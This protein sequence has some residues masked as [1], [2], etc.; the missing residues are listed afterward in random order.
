MPM[1]TKHIYVSVI[2]DLVTDQRVH[3]ICET[4]CSNFPKYQL[5]LIGRLKKDSKPV[6]QRTYKVHR[7]SLRFEKGFKFYAEYNLRL[8]LY[9]LV[10]RR[11]IYFSNDLDTLAPNYLVSRLKGASL[12]Y[13]SHEYFTEVPELIGRERVR[14][15]WLRIEKF[16]VPKLKTMFTVNDTLA[17]VYSDLYHIPVHAVR[18]LPKK[19][20]YGYSSTIVNVREKYGIGASDKLIIYQGALNKDR[21]LEEL[22]Q[23]CT[24]LPA[25]Y[26]LLLVGTGDVHHSLLEKSL[27]LGLHQVHFTG[28]IPFNELAA[29]TEAADLGVSLEKSTN[30]NYR[31]ALPNKVFDY[32]AAGIPILVSPLTE[33][34]AILEKHDVGKLLPSHEP[35]DIAHT[36]EEMF[37]EEKK[38]VQWKE[39]TIAAHEEYNWENEEKKLVARLFKVL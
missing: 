29:Y 23:A 4:I 17:E 31:F 37:A 39:N 19:E 24:F 16:I 21:G 18:N 9:L 1:K 35:K 36:I 33:L 22:I 34:S 27:E 2:N 20:G 38:V 5:T 10:R 15:I 30:L 11:G 26:H 6:N 28:Q 3:K 32:I 8:F 14:A 7:M 12:I 25:N 13:D